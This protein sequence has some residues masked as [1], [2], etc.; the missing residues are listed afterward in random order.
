MVGGTGLKFIKES[1]CSTDLLESVFLTGQSLGHHTE[2]SS[3]GVSYSIVDDHV[4]F[5]NLGIPTLDLII[6]FWDLD[7]GWP[8][9]H[10]Q[11]DTIEN[12]SPEN[13]DLTGKTLLQF[14]YQNYNSQDNN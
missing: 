6:K 5:A 12:I 13:L 4:P 10:T 1:H 7:D 3:D 2:F 8:Y 11:Q 9:H 14:M